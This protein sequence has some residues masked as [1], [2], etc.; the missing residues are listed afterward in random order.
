MP[1]NPFGPIVAVRT[2]EETDD[3]RT[4]EGRAIP[5]GGPFNGKDIYRTYFSARTDLAIDLPIKIWYNHGFDPDFGFSTLGHATS[6]RDADD[7]RW[8]QAQIDKRHKYYE[9]RVKPL[10]DQGMLGFSPGSAEHSYQEDPKTG[11]LLAYPVHEISLTP[12]EANPWAQIAARSAE[13]ITIVAERAAMATA[14]INDLPD[15][16]FAYIEDGG[17]KDEQGKT[18]PRSKRHFPIHDAAHVRN[19]LARAPQSPFG[20]K[21]MPAIQAAAKKLGI[22]DAA[23]SAVRAGKRNAKADQDNLDAAHQAAHTILDHTTAAGA[24]CDACTPPDGDS[25]EGASRSADSPP[26]IKIVER[27]NAAFRPDIDAIAAR[28]AKE[29]VSRL[30]G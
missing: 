29:V 4:I 25:D 20:D 22:G 23:K 13:V 28:A 21:A 2:L 12:T 17:D 11:E 27:E 3:T 6:V 10:L 1:D 19:A 7:G 5:Y 9:T 16:A 8:V 15:S 30:T 14:D 26:T 24:N 18:T